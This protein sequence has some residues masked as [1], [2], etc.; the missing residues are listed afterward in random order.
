MARFNRPQTFWHFLDDAARGERNPRLACAGLWLGKKV[1]LLF[2]DRHPEFFHHHH[3]ILPNL[4]FFNRRLI[5]E[6]VSRM[7]SRHQRNSAVYLPISAQLHNPHRLSEQSFNRRPSQR[8]QH[9]RLNQINLLVQKRNARLHFL[10]RGLPIAARLARGIRPAFQN[11]RDVHRV[12]PQ[13][14]GLNDLSSATAPL[15]P[16]KALL[17]CLH[18]LPGLRRRTSLRINVAH[19]KNDIFSRR[20]QMRAFE[21]AI[22][23]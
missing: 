21:Q 22:A 11:I 4:S 9:F 18:P 1:A 7:I 13:T 12:A 15:F 14:H 6:H 2:A 8:H 10:R 3:H 16:Q 19:P 23:R 17:E 20:S 5:S